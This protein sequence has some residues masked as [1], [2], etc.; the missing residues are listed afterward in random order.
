MILVLRLLRARFKLAYL[1]LEANLH[2]E[3]E[4]KRDPHSSGHLPVTIFS[5]S[6]RL[7]FGEM[8]RERTFTTARENQASN[9]ARSMEHL[10]AAQLCSENTQALSTRTRSDIWLEAV[11]VAAAARSI[12]CKG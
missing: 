9:G 7:A 8:Q 3:R 1:F 2:R 12:T 10:V 4:G 6:Y 5:I 11:A